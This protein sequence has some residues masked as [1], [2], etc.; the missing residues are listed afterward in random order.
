VTADIAVGQM[1][2]IE[3]DASDEGDW[4]FHCH[5]SHHTMNAMAHDLPTM[6]GVDQ[7]GVVEQINRLVPDYMVM[8]NRGMADMG[9]MEMALPDNTLPMMTGTG[10][11]GPM[12]M[13]G[14]FTVVKIRKGL[15]RGDYADPGWYAPPDGSVAR[16]WT[17][18]APAAATVPGQSSGPRAG[19]ALKMTARKPAA[20]GNH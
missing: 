4:A 17:G 14:M 8:G 5:K 6:I 10:P 3:F 2:A 19:S 15:A 16:E 20:R 9:A 7:R 1:R 13:G 11:H 12:D 18:V